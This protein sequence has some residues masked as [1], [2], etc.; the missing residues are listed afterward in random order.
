LKIHVPAGRNES[1]TE[2][3][4]L[5]VT[6]RP[7]ILL[8]ILPLKFKSGYGDNMDTGILIEELID[9]DDTAALSELLTTRKKGSR[10]SFPGHHFMR[11]WK[12]VCD[13][14]SSL[15][16][17]MLLKADFMGLVES[18]E[19]QM[20]FLTSPT[21]TL[22]PT[23]GILRA[24][25]PTEEERSFFATCVVVEDLMT[26]IIQYTLDNIELFRSCGGKFC[27][28]V[29]AAFRRIP[30]ALDNENLI[31]RVVDVDGGGPEYFIRR[32]EAS[33]WWVML[34]AHGGTSK[35]VFELHEIF[36]KIIQ[37]CESTRALEI[38][39]S[40]LFE[41]AIMHLAVSAGW[42]I[43][44]S[45]IE[46]IDE[47]K[48]ELPMNRGH[49]LPVSSDEFRLAQMSLRSI[50]K[51]PHVEPKPNIN[52]SKIKINHKN[53]YRSRFLQECIAR[54]GLQGFELFAIDSPIV[55]EWIVANGDIEAAVSRYKRV[56]GNHLD[57]IQPC[58]MGGGFSNVKK[59]RVRH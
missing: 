16:P 6:K 35:E 19:A 59:Q 34:S 27:E 26:D 14:Q 15:S 1:N 13:G 9:R 25:F 29:L 17:F 32:L 12:R 52:L 41:I 30:S 23:K 57:G 7:G 51:L 20:Y 50:L 47:F 24:L 10:D 46:E 11:L 37:T 3:A 21:R 8:F 28:L 36:R 54:V 5:H 40:S 49:N 55:A 44:G 39:P 4:K 58:V 31:R 53:W 42:T 56:R 22:V 45:A 18:E 48:K 38:S 43:S 33:S 2:L